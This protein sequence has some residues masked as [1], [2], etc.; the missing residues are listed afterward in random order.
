MRLVLVNSTGPMG[1]SVVSAVIE[2]LGYSSIPVRD[3]GIHDYLMGEP[4]MN[5]DVIRDRYVSKFE[6]LSKPANVGGVS[7]PDRDN[8]EARCLLDP[9]TAAVQINKVASSNYSSLADLYENLQEV[10]AETQ[11]Y[12]T[13]TN[14]SGSYVELTTNFH[15][16]D[17]DTCS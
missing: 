7:I 8:T 12:K 15:H 16:Y 10:F 5:L 13:S 4:E 2:H 9:N 17:L 3:L 14:C 6:V 11:I 1:S